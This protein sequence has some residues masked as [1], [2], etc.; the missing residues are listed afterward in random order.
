[1]PPVISDIKI[2][3]ISDTGAT[4][5]WKTSE[6]ATGLLQYGTSASYGQ[7][8]EPA[9]NLAREHTLQLKDLTPSTSYHFLVRSVDAS[10][11][12][13]VST[14]TTF[15]TLEAVKIGYDVGNRAPDFTLKTIDGKT[16]TLSALRGQ[17]VVLNFWRIACPACVYEL[18]FIE[19]VYSS[20]M[21]NKPLIY[22]VNLMDY[23][24]HVN[25]LVNENHYTFPILMDFKGEAMSAYGLRSIPMTYFID[26]S[27]IIRRVQAGRFEDANEFKEILGSL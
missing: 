23:E 24:E 4:I 11:N 27:G 14:D 12:E 3:D 5:I 6:N 19:E 26:A 16:V 2:K 15:L 8:A 18:P 21:A 25:N 13:A 1:M 22:T 17:P 20:Q 10:G 7:N 9:K